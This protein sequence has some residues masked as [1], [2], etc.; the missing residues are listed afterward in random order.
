MG[1]ETEWVLGS[2]PT[3]LPNQTRIPCRLSRG[4]EVGISLL[5]ERKQPRPPAKSQ[6][7]TKCKRM[8]ECKDSQDVGLGNHHLKVRNSL[9]VGTAAPKRSGRKSVPKL[10]TCIFR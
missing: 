6:I 10:R 7:R 8:W 5:L 3:T 9:L 4:S 1:V 2:T